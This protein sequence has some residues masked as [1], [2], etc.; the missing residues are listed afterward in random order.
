MQARLRMSPLM[1]VKTMQVDGG[2]HCG[3][4]TCGHPLRRSNDEGE[5]R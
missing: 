4:S 3:H 5:I 2:C 1:E